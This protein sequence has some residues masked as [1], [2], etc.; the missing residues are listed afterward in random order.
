M[1]STQQ[2]QKIMI[3]RYNNKG[4]VVVRLNVE[5]HLHLTHK[6]LASYLLSYSY[7]SNYP[8]SKLS[9]I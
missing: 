1:V 2:V 8:I 3:C 6:L 7:R 5:K 4:K 9:K